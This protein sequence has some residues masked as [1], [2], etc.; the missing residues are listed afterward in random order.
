MRL[1]RDLAERLAIPDF[2]PWHGEEDYIN[3]LLAPQRT[4]DGTSLTLELLRQ[5]GGIWQKSRLSHVAYPDL[6]FHTPS[7][8]VEFRSAR[9]QSVGLPALPTYTAPQVHS[10]SLY[11]LQFRQGRTLTAFHAFYDEGR[12]LPSLARA[13]PEP[14]LWIHPTDAQKRAIAGNSHILI[15]NGQGELRARARVTEQILPGVVWMRDGWLGLNSLTN[16]AQALSPAASGVIDP[17]GIPGGQ[18]AFD[19]QVEVRKA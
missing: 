7:G 12:A 18:T 9:A 6:H 11:P 14:E 2:F 5:H 13:N 17:L 1:M 3:A 8:K 16:G 19:A 15:Y 4:E 10:A